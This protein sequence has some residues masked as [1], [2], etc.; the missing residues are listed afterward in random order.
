MSE[1]KDEDVYELYEQLLREYKE[2]MTT[3][4]SRRKFAEDV[5]EKRKQEEI[6]KILNDLG[7]VVNEIHSSSGDKTDLYEKFD[8]LVENFDEVYNFSYGGGGKKVNKKNKTGRK[9]NKTGR[10]KN[11]TGR[12]KN[13]KKNRTTNK[14]K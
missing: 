4:Q 5:H 11:K 12:K 1:K 7:D 8:N 2:E 14:K 6:D 10:K 13:G 9:K 3:S